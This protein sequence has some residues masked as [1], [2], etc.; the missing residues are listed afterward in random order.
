M[1]ISGWKLLLWDGTGRLLPVIIIISQF[2]WRHIDPY[3]VNFGGFLK[4]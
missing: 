4:E 2:L 1:L 3:S